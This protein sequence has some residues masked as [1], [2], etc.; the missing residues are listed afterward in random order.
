MDR[1]RLFK[2]FM[3]P[4]VDD[5]V[6]P[7]L[8]SGYIG[9]G[10]QVQKFEREL[11]QATGLSNI[12]TVNS[13]T[14]ALT[15]ALR[16]AK[17]RPGDIVLSTPAT[18][19]A[20]NVPILHLG[21]RV[22][23][24]DVDP[25]TGCVTPKTVYEALWQSPRASAVMVVDYGGRLCDMMGIIDAVSESRSP[26]PIIEDAAHAFGSVYPS[27]LPVGRS[28]NFTCFT[29]QA[30][31]N[32]TCGDGG[33]IICANTHDYEDAR[34][35]RWYGFDRSLSSSMRC[36]QDPPL[37]GY[38]FHMNDISA[39]I[40]RA[41]LRHH[42]VLVA[43]SRC[44]ASRYNNE[45]PSCM[46]PPFCDGSIYWLFHV[47]VDSPNDFMQFMDR[48][49]IDCSQVHGRNDTKSIFMRSVDKSVTL[50]GVDEFYS[51]QVCIPV[52]WWLS[53]NDVNRIIDAVK[54]YHD[55]GHCCG[56]EQRSKSNDED[57]SKARARV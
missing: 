53:P 1:I 22:H 7:V 17:V 29:F 23:W 3:S 41:N 49:G 11:A 50:P 31:K 26:I 47:L 39:S 9:E 42:S 16:L 2:V 30:I 4:D 56:C 55:G 5:Y 36:L 43:K 20:T 52:G 48:N 54:E 27:G 35:M 24:I 32:V 12:C 34:L 13:G 28:A 40:G 10:E 38:K 57:L 18:C 25:K 46:L 14:S 21:A 51:H 44:V 37:A 6:L 8:H 15:M 45:L 33:A 19:I